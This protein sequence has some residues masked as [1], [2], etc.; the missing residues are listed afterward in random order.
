[1]NKRVWGGL[2]V[3]LLVRAPFAQEQ[4]AEALNTQRDRI[5]AAAGDYCETLKN[6]ALNFVCRE[7]IQEKTH[8]FARS[9]V[10]KSAQE[11]RRGLTFLPDLRRTRT[12]KA[13]FIYDYQ[14][15]K[16]GGVLGEK[17]DLL[18]ENGKKK[19]RTDV[20]LQ[21][22]RMTGRYI[23][24]GPVGFLSRSWQPHFEY[25]ILGTEILGPTRAIV[26]RAKPRERTGEND[27]AGRIWLD[28]SGAEIL[29]IEWEPESILNYRESVDSPIGELKR[30]ISW[31]VR[32]DVVKN[33]LRFPSLQTVKEFLT[34]PAGTEHLKYEAEYVF[35]GY[36][37][38]TVETEVVIK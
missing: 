11:R 5:L 20:E 14:L 13:S 30:K 4:P 8:E 17:R 19:T 32:F 23:V 29:Q 33:G 24:Y 27:C 10:F 7:N 28:P 26:L 9:W 18:E 15:I 21:A 38:F 36:K 22:G 31:T 16:K 35:D 6:M 34:T 3:L 1:V 37:F 12:V 25:E 2:V